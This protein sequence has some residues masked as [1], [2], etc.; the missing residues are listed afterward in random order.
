MSKWERFERADFI[1]GVKMPSENVTKYGAV[2]YVTIGG[3]DRDI[4]EHVA[5]CR[6][7]IDLIADAPALLAAL[8]SLLNSLPLLSCESFHHARKDQHS[9]DDECP[10]FERYLAEAIKARALIAK[11]R[12]KV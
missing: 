6:A 9:H 10:P 8:E 5:E 1:M 2:R 12:G 3:F 11:H 7:I 4:P